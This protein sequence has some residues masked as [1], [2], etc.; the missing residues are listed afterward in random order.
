MYGPF[1]DDDKRG[2]CVCL[3]Q[4]RATHALNA[5]ATVPT[6]HCHASESVTSFQHPVEKSIM[7]HFVKKNLSCIDPTP[8]LVSLTVIRKDLTRT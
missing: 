3:S 1:F 7:H 6:Q 8:F 5:H 2:I 4:T